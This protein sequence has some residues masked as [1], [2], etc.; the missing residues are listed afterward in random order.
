MND[1]MRNKRGADK[2]LSVYWFVVLVLISGGVFAMAYSFYGVPYD[3]REVESEILA[4][5]TAD[6]ISYG[7]I[8]NAGLIDNGVLNNTFE[9]NFQEECNLDFNPTSEWKE[10]Q[11]FVSIEFYNI[12]D[13]TGNVDKIN[14]EIKKGNINLISD[15]SIKTQKDKDYERM[16]K[17]TEKRLYSV[18]N[19]NHQYLI[20]ILSGV[21]KSE[22]NV[23]L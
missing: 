6:C 23:K 18:D 9:D 21:R 5:K 12:S 22:K 11:Y 19:Y 1:I 8:I 10:M 17:C 20:K 16:V 15:C 7:G 13:D 3:I 14:F 2:V 4:D